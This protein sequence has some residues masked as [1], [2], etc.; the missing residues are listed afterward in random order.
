[1]EHRA[2]KEILSLVSLSFLLS[3]FSLSL[4][5]RKKMGR[6]WMVVLEYIRVCKGDHLLL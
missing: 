5:E 4:G 3:F 2:A 1:M 6:Q